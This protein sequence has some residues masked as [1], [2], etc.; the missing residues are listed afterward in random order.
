MADVAQTSFTHTYAGQE[1]LTELFYQP[2]ESVPA[3]E[4]LYKVMD[5]VDKK[6]IYLPQKLRKVLRKYT[7][8]GFSAAGGTFNIT[9]KTIS[10]EKVKVNL[11][12]CVDTWTDTIF[13][14]AMKRGVSVDDLSNTIIDDVIRTQ[15]AAGIKSDI[16]RIF[17]FA[18][19]NDADSDWNQFD[20]LISLFLDASAD[21]GATC[22]IDSDGTAFETSDALATDGALG[23]MK[24]MYGAMNKA[25]RVMNDK[26]FYVT[27]SVYDNLM[28]TYEDT[29]SGVGLL[30]LID[31]ASQLT[32]RG[33]PV[34]AV[35]EWDDSLA[36]ST[37]PHY[38]G[39][40]LAIGSNLIVYGASKNL[41][42]GS[43]VSAGETS[44]KVRY[45]D[46]DDEKMKLISKFK[47]GAEIIHYEYVCIAY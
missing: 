8:C 19:A 45:A 37:N 32:F 39:S 46:D 41:V 10:T 7:T 30:R 4:G 43:D 1:F 27:Y 23:L 35:P 15:L 16:H 3:I 13:A 17:W 9:D 47:L 18:D 44:F 28:E 29:Q 31:G 2:E 38:T 20:G 6:N 21:I 26:K 24:Q 40:G 11:E 22:F 5:V 14:E 36:D 12:E 25:L 34:V 33:I 42:F